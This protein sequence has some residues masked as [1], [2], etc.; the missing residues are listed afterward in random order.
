MA[1][2][3]EYVDVLVDVGQLLCQPLPD[4]HEASLHHHRPECAQRPHGSVSYAV[5]T[6]CSDTAMLMFTT[7][8]CFVG[9]HHQD[10]DDCTDIADKFSND[11]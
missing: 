10:S 3:L 5:L 6:A 9:D 7:E 11:A 2:N 1:V 8:Y 4:A